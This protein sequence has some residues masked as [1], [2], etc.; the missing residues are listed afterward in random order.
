MVSQG[1]VSNVAKIVRGSLRLLLARSRYFDLVLPDRLRP[2]RTRRLF[3]GYQSRLAELRN[4]HNGRPCIVIANGPSLR[5]VDVATLNAHVTIGSNGVYAL[6]SGLFR[7]TYYTL[8][9]FAQAVDREQELARLT[10]TTKIFALY[11]A[12]QIKADKDTLFANVIADS[13]GTSSARMA[14]I[15]PQFS[16]DFSSA[17]FL[18]AS[19]TYINLQL[20]F[21]L[22]CNPVVLVGLDHDYGPLQNKYP[23][24]KL[25]ITPEIFEELRGMHMTSNYHRIGGTFGIPYLDL[26]EKAF[27]KALDV[28][29]SH[30]RTLWNASTNSALSVFPRLELDRALQSVEGTAN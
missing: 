6:N 1:S 2:G 20:A 21:H 18:G 19:I 24:G 12:A 3:R 5:E 16:L 11:N 7:P 8:E 15:Y 22:G 23:P 17:V 10:G 25:E 27:K 26:Q 9:D 13:Y 30:G 14:D 4:V 28:F 29:E